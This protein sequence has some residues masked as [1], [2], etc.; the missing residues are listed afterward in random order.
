VSSSIN[1][2]LSDADVSRIAQAVA[3]E[4]RKQPSAELLT[5]EQTARKTGLSLKALERRRSR[6]QRPLAVRRGGRVR[7][8]ASE[9][10]AFIAGKAA[11]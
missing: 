11:S 7:Y 10:D 9:V 1:F 2:T 3:V 8:L 6:N 4:L 5:P